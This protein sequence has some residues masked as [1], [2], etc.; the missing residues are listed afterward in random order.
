[1]GFSDDQIRTAVLKMLKKYDGD[2]TGY[3]EGQE[4]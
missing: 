4:R 3:I 1:M 2:N